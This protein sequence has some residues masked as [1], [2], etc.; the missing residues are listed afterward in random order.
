MLVL[1]LK[2]GLKIIHR[3]YPYSFNQGYQIFMDLKMS[4]KI[5]LNSF[6]NNKSQDLSQLSQNK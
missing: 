1:Y 2:V 4:K 6:N 3:M 5:F